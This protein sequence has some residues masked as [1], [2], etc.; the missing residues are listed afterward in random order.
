VS[1]L[2]KAREELRSA[3]KEIVETA[4]MSTLDALLGEEQRRLIA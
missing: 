3:K 1:K 4:K 2:H